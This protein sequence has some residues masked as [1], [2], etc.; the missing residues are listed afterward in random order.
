MDIWQH[1]V[2]DVGSCK[3]TTVTIGSA[4]GV[5]APAFAQALKHSFTFDQYPLQMI[6]E[7]RTYTPEQGKLSDVLKRFEEHTLGIWARLGIR[8]G[9]FWTTISK[10]KDHRLVYFLTW[11]SLEARDVLWTRFLNDP[12]WLRAKVETESLGPIVAR[13]DSIFLEPALLA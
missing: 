2:R 5:G 8:T 13:I 1:D 12:E 6:Y 10:S 9:G 11:E 7:L 3:D 4:P